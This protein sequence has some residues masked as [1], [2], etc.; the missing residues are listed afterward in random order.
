MK[1]KAALLMLC[2]FLLACTATASTPDADQ[3]AARDAAERERILRTRAAALEEFMAQER[4]CYN[5][6]AVYDCLTEV[7]VRQRA[8]LTDLRR[9]EVSLSDA[10]RKRRAAEQLLR[11]DERAPR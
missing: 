10:R 2:A 6:F 4:D 7:R 9:Q 5:R 3:T 11:S 1:A 8:T